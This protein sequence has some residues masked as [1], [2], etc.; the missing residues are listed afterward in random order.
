MPSGPSLLPVLAALADET[1]LA[2]VERLLAEGEQTA[3]VLAEP[4]PI[5]KPALSRHLRILEESGVIERRIDRQWRIY[6]VRREALRELAEWVE[7]HRRFWDASLDR[8]E[9]V[10]L[11]DDESRKENEP[12]A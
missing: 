7:R 1:R 11:A 3:G 10:L 4:F 9:K 2:I 12:D 5:S 8:L 6:R